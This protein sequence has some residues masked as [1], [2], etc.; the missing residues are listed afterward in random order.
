LRDLWQ[1]AWQ[2]FNVISS[3][4][5]DTNA[6]VISVLFYFTILVPFGIGSVML[7]DPLRKKTITDE[8]GNRKNVGLAWL[9]RDPVP[10]D[11]DSA[12]LQG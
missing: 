1:V 9:D 7:T 8:Q 5:G 6:R 11:I 2:R 4:I 3:I 12:R 10:T